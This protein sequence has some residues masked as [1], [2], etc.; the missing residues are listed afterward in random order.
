MRRQ[1]TTPCSDKLGPSFTSLATSASCSEVSRGFGPGG[2][3]LDSPATPRSLYRCTQSRSVWRS[4]PH[5]TAASVRG[6]PSRT[7]AKASI[8]R[9]ASES[10]DCAAARRSPDASNSIRVI[11]T[12]MPPPESNREKRITSCGYWE[13][14]GFCEVAHGRRRAAMLV[15]TSLKPDWTKPLPPAVTPRS[16][17]WELTGNC[18]PAKAANSAQ[19]AR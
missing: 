3:R 13:S 2:M 16:F 8:R 5:K 6:R 14:K 4:M 7:R 12:A 17:E 10:R 15:A 1:R 9:D 19:M 11:E 18:E